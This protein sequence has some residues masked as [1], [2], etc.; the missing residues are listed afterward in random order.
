MNDL[1]AVI[2]NS[3]TPIQ[4]VVDGKVLAEAVGRKTERNYQANPRK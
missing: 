1:I 3:T 2:T 4:L